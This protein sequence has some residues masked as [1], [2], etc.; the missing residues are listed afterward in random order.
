MYCTVLFIAAVLIWNESIRAASP[1]RYPLSSTD[2][3]LPCRVEHNLPSG[4]WPSVQDTLKKRRVL[5][6]RSCTCIVSSRIPSGI[7]S[8]C[9]DSKQQ[10]EL[11]VQWDVNVYKE[12][13]VQEWFD[14][15]KNGYL[16]MNESHIKL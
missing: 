8:A 16:R 4:D 15:I 7:I 11:N 10:L 12:E 5:Q 14:E 3:L 2:I 9:D 1:Q 6:M 13:T